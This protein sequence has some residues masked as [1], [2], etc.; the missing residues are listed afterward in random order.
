MVTWC[1]DNISRS[2]ITAPLTVTNR[3]QD[4]VS[5]TCLLDVLQMHTFTPDCG[6]LLQPSIIF[7]KKIVVC[8]GL[9]VNFTPLL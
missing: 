2:L 5:C 1:T 4:V 6:G 9:K 8:A 7:V 3:L